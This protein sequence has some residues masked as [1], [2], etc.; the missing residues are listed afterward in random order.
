MPAQPEIS[1]ISTGW[2]L[3]CLSHAGIT[4]LGEVYRVEIFGLDLA[5]RALISQLHSSSTHS[6]AQDAWQNA[7]LLLRKLPSK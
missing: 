1:L 2:G 3:C 4:L 5:T 7:D 6:P